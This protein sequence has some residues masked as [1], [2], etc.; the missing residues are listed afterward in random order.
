MLGLLKKEKK[1][2]RPLFNL[3]ITLSGWQGPF[4]NTWELRYMAEVVARAEKLYAGD[5]HVTED[6]KLN[7]KHM[8]GLHI[9]RGVVDLRE[10]YPLED[11][12]VHFDDELVL[13]N[14]RS[15]EYITVIKEG[16]FFEHPLDLELERRYADITYVRR[17]PVYTLQG[18]YETLPDDKVNT[19][20]AALAEALEQHR[21]Y[22]FSSASRNKTLVLKLLEN[23]YRHMVSNQ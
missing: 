14:S 9:C 19:K 23:K 17:C 22:T 16:V 1:L 10:L 3:T 8:Q 4:K 6:S 12:H 21:G 13:G 20:I 15:L 2:A 5:F 18:L 11:A 7:R